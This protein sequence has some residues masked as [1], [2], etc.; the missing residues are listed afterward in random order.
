MDNA[1]GWNLHVGEWMEASA[2]PFL[3]ARNG[4]R[5]LDDLPLVDDPFTPNLPMSIMSFIQEGRLAI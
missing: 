2:T 3:E 5:K 4:L 1:P